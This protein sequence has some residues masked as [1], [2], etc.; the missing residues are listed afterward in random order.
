MGEALEW[1]TSPPLLW[2]CKE[3]VRDIQLWEREGEEDRRIHSANRC[4]SEVPSL[5]LFDFILAFPSGI[6][7][8]IITFI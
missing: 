3:F 7:S 6:D 8:E 5:F 4:D 2:V 1:Y